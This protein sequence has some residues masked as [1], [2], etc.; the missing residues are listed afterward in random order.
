MEALATPEILFLFDPEDY[1]LKEAMDHDNHLNLDLI[2][3]MYKSHEGLLTKIEKR[4]STLNNRNRPLSSVNKVEDFCWITQSC[5]A[6]LNQ[7]LLDRFK[8]K[9]QTTLQWHNII[10]L[11]Y[12]ESLVNT[13]ENMRSCDSM[14][15]ASQINQDFESELRASLK[16]N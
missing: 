5:Y 16:L 4:R 12:M 10:I 14:G 1:E 13:V 8:D 11:P 3:S 7:S 2:Y 6:K 9:N 15:A